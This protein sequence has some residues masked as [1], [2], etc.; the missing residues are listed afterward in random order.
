MRFLQNLAI[1]RSKVLHFLIS[2]IER[3]L[4]GSKTTILRKRMIN[5]AIDIAI[6]WQSL[7]QIVGSRAIDIFG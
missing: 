7:S 5:L 3:T 2:D 4:G 6:L 1:E